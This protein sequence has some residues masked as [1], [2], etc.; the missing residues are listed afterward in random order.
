M[1]YAKSL[2]LPEPVKFRIL[3]AAKF[4]CGHLTFPKRRR[5]AAPDLAPHAFRVAAG[6]DHRKKAER[7]EW[8]RV[9]LEADGDGGWIAAKFPRDGAGILSSMVEADGLIELAEDVTQLKAGTMVDFLPFSE[10]R[11]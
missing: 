9:R 4:C 7:R 8:V 1:Q 10:F 3:P 11:L 5:C 2:K 6:F